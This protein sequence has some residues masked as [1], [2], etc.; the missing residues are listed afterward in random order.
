[1]VDKG[2]DSGSTST[3]DST[4]GGDTPAAAPTTTAVEKAEVS[5]LNKIGGWIKNQATKERKGIDLFKRRPISSK[6]VSSFFQM[7]S[8][9]MLVLLGFILHFG[10]NYV[11]FGFD[12]T[13][14][15]YLI[16]NFVFAVLV[17][18][19]FFDADMKKGAPLCLGILFLDV[20]GWGMIRT[21]MGANIGGLTGQLWNYVFTDLFWPTWAILGIWVGRTKVPRGQRDFLVKAGLIFLIIFWIVYLGAG[22]AFAQT[23]QKMNMENPVDMF[24]NE[25]G[26]EE[27]DERIEE[28]QAGFKTFWGTTMTPM[29]DCMFGNVDSCDKIGKRPPP[30]MTLDELEGEISKLQRES[31]D[32]RFDVFNKDMIYLEQEDILLNGMLYVKSLNDNLEIK[33]SG[34]MDGKS[35]IVEGEDKKEKIIKVGKSLSGQGSSL[36]FKLE[37]IHNYQIGKRKAKVDLEINNVGAESS[38]YVFL[39]DRNLKELRDDFLGYGQEVTQEKLNINRQYFKIIENNGVD[40]AFLFLYSMVP[41]FNE[42][43]M[44]KYPEYPGK[45]LTSVSGEGFVNLIVNSEKPPIINNKEIP[46]TIGIENEEENGEIISINSVTFEL[47]EGFAP[48]QQCLSRLKEGEKGKYEVKQDELEQIKGFKFTETKNQKV[49][50]RCYL[51]VKNVNLM[52]PNE[53]NPFKIKAVMN[54]NYKIT[55]EFALQVDDNENLENCMEYV[56]ETDKSNVNVGYVEVE[57]C[58][59]SINKLF[60]RS[61]SGLNSKGEVFCRKGKEYGINPRF[62]AAVAA[63]ESAFGTSKLAKECNNFFGIKVTGTEDI[64]YNNNDFKRFDSVD[65]GINYFYN[66]IKNYYYTKEQ[67]TVYDIANG[68]DSRHDHAYVC[69]GREEWIKNIP[70]LMG[71]I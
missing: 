17:W 43:I 52:N 20:I 37:G 42:I 70:I 36:S 50:F 21:L 45:K 58:V 68:V 18:I 39:T 26:I 1:M 61:D 64:C 69:T 66:L 31:V 60:S 53:L 25:L 27:A 8:Y 34:E 48:N 41:S 7:G 2:T 23:V 55:E 24:S 22:T 57:D 32:L 16:V 59:K 9:G 44:T 12:V 47:P 35:F 28:A 14:Y 6:G 49:L 46:I 30:K 4:P 63:H 15:D 67:K 54:Y 56:P 29:F 5:T 38:L 65:K 62:A 11:A 10:V 19:I 13:R 33:V 40:D 51:N 71:N 3:G